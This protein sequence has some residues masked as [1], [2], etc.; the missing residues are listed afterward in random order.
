MKPIQIHPEVR[1]SSISL[2]LLTF[3]PIFLYLDIDKPPFEVTET[4]YV[5]P[6]LIYERKPCRL[7]DK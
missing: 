7:I 2:K 1:C 6:N 4:G 5:P 3:S